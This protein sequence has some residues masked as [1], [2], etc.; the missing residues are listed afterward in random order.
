MQSKRDLIVVQEMEEPD[1]E[2]ALNVRFLDEIP[3]TK[4][5]TVEKKLVEDEV[6]KTTREED[7]QT[8]TVAMATTTEEMKETK[9]VTEPVEIETTSEPEIQT[10]L[11]PSE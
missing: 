4:K 10:T 8:E 5:K 3:L 7:T 6:G 1:L 11:N 9:P 2:D